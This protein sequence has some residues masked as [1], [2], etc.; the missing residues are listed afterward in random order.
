MTCRKWQQDSSLGLSF[1]T[2]MKSETVKSEFLNNSD[3]TI[4]YIKLFSPRKFK[5]RPRKL[6]QSSTLCGINLLCHK[7]IEPMKPLYIII[8][9]NKPPY[10]MG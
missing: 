7:S 1:I 4:Y 3:Y 8:K 2:K 9:N 6:R 10:V 5:I